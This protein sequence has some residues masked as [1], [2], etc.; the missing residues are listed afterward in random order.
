M[1]AKDSCDFCFPTP[2]AS[3]AVGRT[4]TISGT[5]DPGATM[6]TSTQGFMRSIREVVREVYN[7]SSS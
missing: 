3:S 7:V 5:E 1:N 4:Q 6:E 2:N